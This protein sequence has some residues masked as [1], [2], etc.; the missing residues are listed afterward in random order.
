MKKLLALALLFSSVARADLTNLASWI[1]DSNGNAINLGQTTM[2]NGLPVTFASNQSS[3]P[4]AC[5]QSTAAALSGFWPVKVTDGTN[6]MPTMDVAARAGFMKVTDGTNTM[7]TGDT[8][9]RKIFVQPT[10]GTNSQGY[11]AAS[12]AKVS[13]T[14]PLPAGTNLLGKVGID[15]TTPGTTNGVQVNAALP[16]GTNSIGQVTANAGTNLNTSLLALQSGANSILDKTASGALTGVN[17]AVTVS[18]N[19]M[20]TVQAQLL[21]TF[22]ETVQFEGSI[23]NG[24]TYFS[25]PCIYLTINLIPISQLN[26]T[27]NVTC[28]VSGYTN[29]RVR[30]SA[31]TSGTM[32]VVVN[33]SAGMLAN[34]ATQIVRFASSMG[35]YITSTLITGTAANKQ[36][37]DTNNLSTGTLR[38]S[39]VFTLQQSAATAVNSSVFS[40]RNAAAATKTAII[41]S[42][43]CRM[44]FNPT[45]P[46]TRTQQTYIFQRFSAATPTGGTALTAA[47]GDSSDAASQV[48]DI[49][50]LDTGLTTTGVTFVANNIAAMA[51]DTTQGTNCDEHIVMAPT[52]IRLA[53]GEG[54]VVR[55]GVVA[56]IG[57]AI[58]CNIAWREQ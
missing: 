5:T 26:S 8:V 53:P 19:G 17:Q 50:F 38:Y 41:E 18:T 55:L 7:P 30:S 51:C 46:V 29:F 44:G 16:T 23:D 34:A 43:N 1:Y 13:V 25:T 35:E 31:F 54:L 9:A 15:Q 10:D 12:E 4:V 24:T 45:N 11:T 32:N 6:S 39:T 3:I 14:Q 36:P 21:G 37:L 20:T 40:M 57:T 49:R 33:A 58:Q 52:A 56:V 28:Y 2:A 48:T 47:Q 27:G 42:V 22:V